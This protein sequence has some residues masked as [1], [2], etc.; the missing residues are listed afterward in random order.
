MGARICV[1]GAGR[2]GGVAAACLA[3]LGHRVRAVDVDAERVA[4]LSA[5]RAP[6]FEPGLDGLLVRNLAA[7]RLSF[8][9][10]IAEAVPE[11]EYIVLAVNTP[12]QGNG[13]ANLAAVKAALHDLTP[14]LEQHAVVVTR[15]TVPVGT[16]GW[17]ARTLRGERPGLAVDVVSNPEFL[18][19]GHGVADFMR[20]DRI[21]IG[22][23]DRP[24]AER[25]AALYRGIECPVVLTD[26]ETAEVAKY[27]ANAY[28]ATS[29]SFM[30][31]IANIC[32]RTGADVSVVSHALAL[33]GRIGP[34]AY[35]SP[36]I[37]F[38]G[39]CLPKDLRALICAAESHG[40]T[41][42]LLRSVRE[43]NELQPARAVDHLREIYDDL[44]G[45]PVAVLGLS[46]KGDTFDLRS[47]PALAILRLLVQAGARVRAFDPFADGTERPE[48]D[49]A[50]E[51]APNAY[52][53]ASG[54]RAAV[55]ATDHAA[56]R[57]LDLERLRGAMASP[58]LI[59]GRNLLDPEAAARAGFSYI[60][61]GRARRGD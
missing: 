14:L 45:L 6:F 22:A 27:A 57:D 56:F 29:I 12:P 39:S 26:L 48:L 46:F 32:E 40:Y 50:V 37:G 31:E 15:S 51:L 23:G 53:A 38:G 28:L 55:I 47:S 20:P 25:V 24:A 2:S 52:A 11:A 35:L 58:V 43:V 3:E 7:G 60:G 17:I 42:A 19:E 8:T 44:D 16:N 34:R 5:G 36:G 49:P 59:D 1:V 54:C 33:D 41:P 13:E 10:A 9:T 21:V 4:G 18:R 61:V 30:N